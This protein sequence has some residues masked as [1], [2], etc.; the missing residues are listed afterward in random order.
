VF[1]LGRHRIISSKGLLSTPVSVEG[2]EAQS[3]LWSAGT[4]HASADLISLFSNVSLLHCVQPSAYERI[5]YSLDRHCTADG[6]AY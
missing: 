1:A 3:A 6:V 2:R 4:R 5:C